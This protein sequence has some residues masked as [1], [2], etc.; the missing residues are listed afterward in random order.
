MLVFWDKD[1][2]LIKLALSQQTYM[3]VLNHS[4]E[5]D[6]T[7]DLKTDPNKCNKRERDVPE[8]RIIVSCKS[9]LRVPPNR[10][11]VNQRRAAESD[12]YK[13]TMSL[14][15]KTKAGLYLL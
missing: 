14:C 8:N 4:R 9:S 15:L 10:R 11:S 12:R 6:V 3:K 1:I 13:E 5:T 2:D 7:Y